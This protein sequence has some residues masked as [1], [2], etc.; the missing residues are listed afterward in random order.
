MMGPGLA[1]MPDYMGWMMFGT[2]LLWAVITAL[3]VFVVV[4]LVRAAD[5]GAKA[6]LDARLARGEID[7]EEYRARLTL[8]SASR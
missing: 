7:A 1:Y 3:A 8:L 2:Y 6:I 4:R 5:S